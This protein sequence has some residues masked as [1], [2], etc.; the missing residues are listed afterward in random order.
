MGWPTNPQEQYFG[1][2][3]WGWASTTWER[4]ASLSNLLGVALHGYDGSAWQKLSLLWGYSD[5]LSESASHTKSGAGTYTMTIATVPAGSVYVVNVVILQNLSSAVNQFVVFYD[6]T[7]EL[8]VK[9][10]SVPAAGVWNTYDNVSYVLKEGDEVR[11]RFVSC[12]DAD[13]LRGYVWGYE[14]GVS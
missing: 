5:R 12:G 10:F 9:K 8:R 7:N 14:M 4:L 13:Q 1:R 11:G 2:G 3:L 6:G